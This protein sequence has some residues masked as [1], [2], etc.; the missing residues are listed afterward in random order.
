MNS[1]VEI[2]FSLIHSQRSWQVFYINVAMR[3]RRENMY[4]C[5]ITCLFSSGKGT[6]CRGPTGGGAADSPAWVAT[7]GYPPSNYPFKWH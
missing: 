4:A 7:I 2:V 5:F 6:Q 1:K 3:D